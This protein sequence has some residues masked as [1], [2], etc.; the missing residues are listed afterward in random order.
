MRW[1]VFILCFLFSL[2]LF[3]QGKEVR[4]YYD[5]E[6]EHLEERYFVKDLQPSVLYGDYESYYISGQLKSKGQ[7]IDD[8]S[9]GL[10]QYYYENGNLKM[11]GQLKDNSNYGKWTYYYENGKISMVGEIYDGSREGEW[12]YYYETGVIKSEGKYYG[13]IKDGLWSY[14]YEDGSLKG[15][16]IYNKGDGIYKEFYPDGTIKLEGFIKNEKSDSIWKS[17]FETG[18]LKSKG[19]YKEGAKEGKWTYFYKNGVVSGEG[20]FLD[21]LSHGKWIYYYE[22]GSIMAEGAER[23]GKKEGFW[24]L[25]YDDGVPKGEG[26]YEAGS[27]SYKEFYESG[28]LKLK[29]QIKNGKND[30]QWVYYYE[31]GE[32][33]GKSIFD[34]GFGEYEGFYKD[35]TLKMKGDIKE[36]VKVG[37]WQLYDDTGKLAGYY[38]PIYEEYEPILRQ[39]NRKN[40]TEDNPKYNKPEY[41]FKSKGASY[42]QAQNNDF[43]TLILQVNPFNMILGDLQLGIEYHIQQRIGYELLLHTYRN[44]FFANSLNLRVGDDFFEGFGFSFRQRFYHKDSNFGMPYFGHSISYTHVNHFK[45]YQN[46]HNNEETRA[47]LDSRSVRY[48]VLVGSRILQNLNDSGFTFDINAGVNFTYYFFGDETNIGDQPNIFNERKSK[49]FKLQPIIGLSFGYVFRLKKVSTLNP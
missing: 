6:N 12:V 7:Y 45:M 48:G 23:A 31:S 19:I 22:N 30:G 24:K 3:P 35:G 5:D 39:A 28:K 33:E 18:E 43:P 14:Y 47:R 41:R 29:G 9:F 10:W 46:Q 16:A 8:E 17:Y 21:N 38:K 32:V 1:I 37:T 26:V 40:S 13:N 11:K 42:F 49:K 44:P 20:E 36:G 15:Q 34:S 27:G 4:K 25:Y 2:N